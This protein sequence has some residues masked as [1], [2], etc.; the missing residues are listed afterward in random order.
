MTFI[1]FYTM[2]ITLTAVLGA[3][4]YSFSH[5]ESDQRR[6]AKIFLFS[7]VWPVILI[8]W[9]FLYIKGMIDFLRE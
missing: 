6:G 2:A 4:H 7:A 3:V 8:V 1:V 5:Y 9:L